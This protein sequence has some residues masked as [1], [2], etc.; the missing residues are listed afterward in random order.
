MK[1][2]ISEAEAYPSAALHLLRRI[3][4][5]LHGTLAWISY[6]A[7]RAS[8]IRGDTLFAARLIAKLWDID[9]W[10]R[11]YLELVLRAARWTP[12]SRRAW[13]PRFPAEAQAVSSDW[14][15]EVAGLGEQITRILA[16]EGGLKEGGTMHSLGDALSDMGPV[17]EEMARQIA[18]ID[19]LLAEARTAPGARTPAPA[20]LIADIRW[21]HSQLDT[22]VSRLNAA[23]LVTDGVSDEPTR[24]SLT[25]GI[26]NVRARVD[27]LIVSTA[28]T[29]REMITGTWAGNAEV[30]RL[31]VADALRVTNVIANLEEVVAADAEE[32]PPNLPPVI[33][34]P[35]KKSS[36]VLPWVIG[37]GIAAMVVIAVASSD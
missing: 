13:N 11:D 15:T 26:A 9:G 20:N 17:L 24:V 35:K 33:L 14:A 12:A 10:I 3:V 1:A 2:R 27:A 4:L 22:D 19:R 30:V 32:F 25:T 7:D 23:Q 21:A 29:E 31:I 6:H 18:E 16:S 34:P 8:R 36:S 28:S 5:E 37:G